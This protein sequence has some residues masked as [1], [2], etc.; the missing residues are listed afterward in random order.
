MMAVRSLNDDLLAATEVAKAIR[1]LTT[2]RDPPEPPNRQLRAYALDPSQETSLDT[3]PI[4]QV[5][6]PTRW[7]SVEPGPIGEYL[8]VVD[9]DPASDCVYAPVDLNHPRILAQDG[10]PPSEGDPQ[11]HQQMVYAV[12]MNTI[13]RFEL[14]LG[15]PIFWAPIRAW[16]REGPDS[17]NWFTPEALDL[18]GIDPDSDEPLPDRPPKRDRYVQRLR[19]Y[20][21]ALREANAYYSPQKR[22]LLFGY[23]PATDDDSGMHY[24]GGMVFTCLSHDIIAHETTHALLDGMHPY[25]NEPSNE[26]VWAFHE[27]FAD[28]IALFQHFTF[29]EVLRHQITHTRGNLE[30]NNLLGQLAQQFGQATG[31]RG[32]L[33]DALGTE[34]KAGWLRRQP[35]PRSLHN[36][37]EPHARGSILVA[38][39]FDAFL[40]LYNE[41]TADLLRLS[42]A[43]TG[44]TPAD[45]IHPDLVNRLAVEAAH[46]ADDVLRIC[47]RAMDYVPPVDITFGEFLRAMIT[48][49]YDLAPAHR[50]NNRIA[51]IDAFRSWGIYPRD[52][53]TLSEDS[54]RWRPPGNEDQLT[55]LRENP[56]FSKSDEKTLREL[57]DALESW[58]PGSQRRN[59]FQHVQ[60][61]QAMFH[62]LLE[63]MQDEVPGGQPLVPGLDLRTGA[64]FSV[65][66]LRPA[67]RVGSQGEFRNEMVVDVIQTYRASDSGKPVGDPPFRGGSTII[68]DARDW[69]VRYVISKRVY[70]ELPACAGPGGIR[71]G[72]AYRQQRFG[73]QRDSSLAGE[74][75]N[76]WRSEATGNLEDWL[77]ATYACQER[78]AARRRKAM[79]AEPFA[80]LHR[81][82][83]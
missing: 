82:F 2:Q 4:S 50:R 34:T 66:N 39:V 6:I 61:A 65:T 15:R 57:A 53:P 24:P 8:E 77:A 73:A 44:I 62:D 30:T 37:Q 81:G 28:I 48:A 49:D 43:G 68:I 10:L 21:H 47:I 59:V 56:G 23:F 74:G 41:R 14:A 25:F 29:P 80:L 58:Q 20:P 79:Y 26:D 38:A 83:E 7:E 70:E 64:H 76:S 5:R 18:L 32:A 31:N 40:S 63:K 52:V 36:V 3:A 12:A 55:S 60:K 71:A 69:T 54:L 45:Q 22:A 16:M 17:E 78:R 13:H 72:R 42:A 9:I 27:A 1:D 33:R 51:F 11:F 46:T 67:R 19:V 35:D 75:A